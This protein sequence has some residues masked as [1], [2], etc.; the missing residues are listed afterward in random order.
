MRPC[1][2]CA[3]VAVLA[4]ALVLSSSAAA[5][6]DHRG[7]AVLG[8]EVNAARE[9]L[10]IDDRRPRFAWQLTSGQQTHYRVVVA[11][12]DGGLSGSYA[13]IWPVVEDLYWNV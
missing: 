1:K 11:T 4:I 10:G 3:S 2:G 5:H 6:A 8:L 13:A 7:P 12:S 9:P